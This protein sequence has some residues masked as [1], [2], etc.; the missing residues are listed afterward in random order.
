MKAGV[1]AAPS[2]TQAPTSVATSWSLKLPTCCAARSSSAVTTCARREADEQRAARREHAALG[3]SAAPGAPAPAPRR[4]DAARQPRM[5]QGNGVA[6][7]ASRDTG[8]RR[9]CPV[10][11]AADA[12]SAA[13][14]VHCGWRSRGCRAVRR[15]APLCH[16]CPLASLTSGL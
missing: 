9:A 10:R 2:V 5:E 7:A 14:R 12:E 4:A 11:R 1:G 16:A 13:L 3:R 15:R 6:P 8:A